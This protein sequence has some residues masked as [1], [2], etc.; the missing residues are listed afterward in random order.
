MSSIAV[1]SIVCAC[2]FGGAALGMV[3]RAVLPEHHLSADSKDVVKMGMGLVATLSALVLGLLIASAKNSSDAQST[4]L[5]QMCA[6]V[7]SLDRLLAHYG[8]EAKEGRDLLRNSVERVLNQMWSKDRTNSSQSEPQAAGGEALF[9]KIQALS[10]KDEAQRSLK[11]KASSIAM[12]IGQM[13]WLMYEQG[14]ASISMPL[15]IVLVF[16]LTALFIS[17]GLFAPRNGTVV[18]SLLVSSLS[19]S[20]AILLILEMYAPYAGVIQVSSAPLRAALSQLGK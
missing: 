12:D 10:P 16:W 11:A 6:K 9:G 14:A 3:L 8:P 7:V 5:T 17:F 19:V 15:L 13:R 2:V 4:E 18:T 1:S 20:G